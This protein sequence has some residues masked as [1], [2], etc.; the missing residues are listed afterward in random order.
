M[1]SQNLVQIGPFVW[2]KQPIYDVQ[3]INEIQIHCFSSINMG[4][5]GKCHL[6]NHFI[7]SFYSDILQFYSNRPI[8]SGD[9]NLWKIKCSILYD[10]YLFKNYDKYKKKCYFFRKIVLFFSFMSV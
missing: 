3:I 5:I 10:A 2:T 7:F 1:A 8:G 4:R 9:A 6:Q